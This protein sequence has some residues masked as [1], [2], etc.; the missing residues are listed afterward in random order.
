MTVVQVPQT[1]AQ[2]SRSIDRRGALRRTLLATTALG[3]MTMA[4]TSPLNAQAVPQG[5]SD[6]AACVQDGATITCTGN[7]S[8]GV[9]AI[10]QDGET[11]NVEDLDQPIA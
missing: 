10:L 11:L 5:T 9:T 6:P 8:G 7:L 1:R 2:S 3:A 4:P